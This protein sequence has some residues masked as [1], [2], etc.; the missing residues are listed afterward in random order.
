MRSPRAARS[1]LLAL[2]VAALLLG[3]VGCGDS[4][5]GDGET[6]AGTETPTSEDGGTTD[7]ESSTTLDDP[8]GQSSEPEEEEETPS[9]GD[10]VVMDGIAFEP[11][12]LTVPVGTEVTW[13][14]QEDLTH[15]TSSEDDVWDSGD[16]EQG[17]EFSHTFEEAGTFPYICQIHSGMTGEVV[18]E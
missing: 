9:S 11:G 18:V 14:N 17:D 8:Y 7:A 1:T 15:T 16:L 13:T 3:A 12:T 5:D 6:S 4:D 10:A 2:V